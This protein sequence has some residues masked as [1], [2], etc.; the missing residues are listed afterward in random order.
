MLALL[1]SWVVEKTRLKIK[2]YRNFLFFFYTFLHSFVDLSMGTTRSFTVL[3]AKSPTVPSK[4][5]KKATLSMC[6]TNFGQ[7]QN[8]SSCDHRSI[9]IDACASRA[10]PAQN[11][12]TTFLAPS[13]VFLSACTNKRDEQKYKKEF[14]DFFSLLICL[15]FTC[16]F[17]PPMTVCRVTVAGR[18]ENLLIHVVPSVSVM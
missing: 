7:T 3:E 4:T 8:R 15:L 18:L 9:Q 12:V 11:P 13:T 1:L 6:C 14:S 17:L 16:D 5:P 2:Q 10:A